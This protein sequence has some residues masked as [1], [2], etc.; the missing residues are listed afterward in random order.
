MVYVRMCTVK[1]YKEIKKWMKLQ[2]LKPSNSNIRRL[3]LEDISAK[4]I[5]YDVECYKCREEPI[6]E[7]PDTTTPQSPVE[8]CT[9]FPGMGS[10]ASG[11]FENCD[12]CYELGYGCFP[13]TG[14]FVCCADGITTT[15]EPTSNETM[16]ST[17]APVLTTSFDPE[18]STTEASDS[19][20]C[21]ES[22]SWGPGDVN[23]PAECSTCTE[24]G[25]G[26][27][28]NAAGNNVSYPCCVWENNLTTDTTATPA[29]S[30]DN[31]PTAIADRIPFPSCE[32]CTELGYG[33]FQDG[34]V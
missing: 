13:Y 12:K 5:D 28:K 29:Q 20:T 33:C 11:A 1:K 15:Q 25:Q 16:P 7:I 3:N 30:C 23:S 8:S 27:Y 14:G 32:N 2:G 34:E 18:L 24:Q 21:P 26:C 31:L 22:A 10:P 19:V 4:G 9:S 17:T 6:I